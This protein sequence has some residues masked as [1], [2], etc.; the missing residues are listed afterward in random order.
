MTSALR[1]TLFL[2][3]GSFA[4][5]AQAETFSCKSQA[6]ELSSIVGQPVQCFCGKDLDNLSVT[7]PTGMKVVGACGLKDARGAAINLA[8]QKLSLD[9]LEKKSAPA[10][11]IYLSGPIALDGLVTSNPSEIGILG[12]ESKPLV[13]TSDFVSKH[14]A[15]NIRLD[16]EEFRRLFNSPKQQLLTPVCFNAPASIVAHDLAV[17]LSA[18]AEAG[19]VA[20]RI[21]VKKMARFMK[22]DPNSR[23]LVQP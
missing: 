21:E 9:R 2:F 5:A 14:L 12:F 8:Q 15:S 22:C 20:R 16:T 4:L 18:G 19:S 11:F 1:T 7:L 3:L 23:R 6:A 17:T 10:G 13:S